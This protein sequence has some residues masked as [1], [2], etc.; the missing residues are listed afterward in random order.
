[1]RFWAGHG[2]FSASYYYAQNTA[3]VGYDGY[4]FIRKQA[5]YLAVGFPM[6]LAISYI[7]FRKLERFK[8]IGI[9]VPSCCCSLFWVVGRKRWCETLDRHRRSKYSAF[10]NCKIRYDAL[11]VLLHGEEAPGHAELY[12]GHAAHAAGH[13]YYLRSGHVAA[14]YVHAVIMV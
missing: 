2:L 10:R 11:H 14:E 6:M 7:D 5:V 4:Y 13:W 3:S 12:K 8:L 1:L 9:L